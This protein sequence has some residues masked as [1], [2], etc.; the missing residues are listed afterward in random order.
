LKPDVHVFL[1]TMAAKL[2]FEMAPQMQPPFLQGTI[3]VVGLMLSM[4]REEWDRAAQRRVEENEALRALFRRAAPHIGG[5][6]LR[7][8]LLAAAASREASL[9]ISDLDAAND[10]LRRLLIELQA[11]VEERPGAEARRLEAEIWQELVA[12]TERR[13]F[14]IA[15]F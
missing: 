10:A 8:R 3:S 6:D 11:H 4:L 12:S 9:R 2:M 1:E 14:S 7:R 13:R 15:P 5:E